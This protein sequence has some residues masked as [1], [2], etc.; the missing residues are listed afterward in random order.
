MKMSL[1]W[2]FVTLLTFVAAGPVLANDSTAELAAGGL[3]MVKNDS[4][5]MRAEDLF[6]SAKQIRVRYKFF[7]RSDKDVTVR[8]AFPIPD[9]S[10]AEP[11]ANIS[12]PTEDPVNI[13]GFKTSVNGKPV[14]MDVEQ[15]VFVG[16]TEYTKFL[17]NLGVPLAPHL[18][19]TGNALEKLPADKQ[20]EFVRQKLG[21]IE[22]FD[23]G[24]GM[25]KH[26]TPR[27]T[28][29]T[30]YHWEQ[31]FPARAETSIE[32]TYVPSV[33]QS[34]GSNVNP[35][36]PSETLQEYTKKYCIDRDFL[37]SVERI[38]KQTKTEYGGAVHRGPDR[39]YPHDRSETVR[40]DPRLPLVVDKGAVDSLI[41]F[42]GD[43]VKKIAATQFEMKKTDFTPKGN[44]A[45]LILRRIPN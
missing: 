30:N 21:E 12:V 35:S 6:I 5:E 42:C 17:T 36:D 45:V 27:W 39:I 41:S 9:I 29:R 19:A 23:Q 7:N 43:G 22:E 37:S 26:L 11:D 13:F 33:G 10:T 24:K 44:F 1:K 18:A 4:I 20:A 15:R 2:I 38:K 28:L 8:V 14:K 31:T 25:E 16:E 40:T 32:H 34:A 3:V